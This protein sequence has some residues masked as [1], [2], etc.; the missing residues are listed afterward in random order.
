MTNARIVCRA[1]KAICSTARWQLF[2][3]AVETERQ[4]VTRASSWILMDNK[5]P[6]NDLH[7]VHDEVV[8]HFDPKLA[9]RR[10]FLEA[11]LRILG[12]V[13]TRCP[14]ASNARLS[15]LASSTLFLK[16]FRLP[17]KS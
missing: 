7:D 2:V 14:D 8:A 10:F 5:D 13:V 12:F 6:Q 1:I 11:S 17:A 9:Q 3:G 4:S 15:R 16:L